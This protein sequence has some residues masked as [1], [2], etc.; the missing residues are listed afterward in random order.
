MT[1]NVKTPLNVIDERI[2]A[3]EG[4]K[5]LWGMYTLAQ[6]KAERAKWYDDQGNPIPVTNPEPEYEQYSPAEVVNASG[7]WTTYPSLLREPPPWVDY[8]RPEQGLEISVAR[9]NG[10]VFVRKEV[11]CAEEWI[12]NSAAVAAKLGASPRLI[13]FAGHFMRGNR[14][15]LPTTVIDGGLWDLGDYA[16]KPEVPFN[17]WEKEHFEDLFLDHNFSAVTI[18]AVSTKFVSIG[19][20]YPKHFMPVCVNRPDMGVVSLMEWFN[21]GWFREKYYRTAMAQAK[22]IDQG[23]MARVEGYTPPEQ[24]GGEN[25]PAWRDKHENSKPSEMPGLWTLGPDGL[26]R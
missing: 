19:T 8:S 3:L 9:S 2:A 20:G 18:A 1:E 17:A 24:W 14:Y 6:L 13:H 15:L 4:T 11:E 25:T 22:A 5:N 26:A 21:T 10:A 12:N 7:W 16:V 23:R